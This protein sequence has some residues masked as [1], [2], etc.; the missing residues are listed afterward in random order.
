MKAAYLY[1]TR[2]KLNEKCIVFYKNINLVMNI[3]KYELTEGHRCVWMVRVDFIKLTLLS[4]QTYKFNI[5]F[6][7]WK[8]THSLKMYKI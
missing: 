3:K 6:R 1:A 5:T 8:L 2:C 7:H 4:Q